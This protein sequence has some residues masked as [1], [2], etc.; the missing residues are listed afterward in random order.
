MQKSTEDS[1]GPVSVMLLSNY[2]VVFYNYF[3]CDFANK[4]VIYQYFVL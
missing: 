2:Y 3:I 1:L 4:L